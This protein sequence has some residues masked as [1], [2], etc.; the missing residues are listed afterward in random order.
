MTKQITKQITVR[1]WVE[2]NGWDANGEGLEV[3]IAGLTIPR[4][5]WE[6][7]EVEPEAEIELISPGGF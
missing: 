6:N 7:V 2:D 4:S 5:Q 1:Q 3:C